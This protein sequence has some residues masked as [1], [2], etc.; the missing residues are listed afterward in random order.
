[1]SA[2]LGGIENFFFGRRQRLFGTAESGVLVQ[3]SDV[4]ELS[5]TVRADM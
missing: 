2:F 1:M 5:V 4:R 3:A